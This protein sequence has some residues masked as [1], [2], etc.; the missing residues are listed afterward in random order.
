V[1]EAGLLAAVTEAE[2]RRSLLGE[3]LEREL[4]GRALWTERA[5]ERHS[6]GGLRRRAWLQWQA[7]AR[8]ARRH[9]AAERRMATRRRGP[10]GAALRR[11]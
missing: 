1:A 8:L 2:A 7:A 9:G 10:R 4:A 5:A 11:A 3:Q 6:S